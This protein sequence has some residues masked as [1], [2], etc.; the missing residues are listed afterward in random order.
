MPESRPTSPL[1][2]RF[3][4]LGL[5]GGAMVLLPLAQVLRYQT[6]E[7]HALQ[8]ERSALDPMTDALA[9]QR[10]LLQHR[11]LAH[12]VLTGRTQFERERRMRQRTVD[13]HVAT[14]GRA[15]I[16]GAWM[17]A[18]EESQA[19]TDDWNVLAGRVVARSISAPASDDEHRLRVEQVLQVIDLLSLALGRADAAGPGEP[20]SLAVATATLRAL[21]RLTAQMQA[22][23]E[24][25]RDLD[26][27]A[28]AAGARS[29]ERLQRSLQA[30]QATLASTGGQALAAAGLATAAQTSAWAAHRG[31]PDADGAALAA[32]LQAQAGLAAAAARQAEAALAQQQ[33]AVEGQRAALLAA[34]AALSCTALWLWRRRPLPAAGG[35]VPREP[36]AGGDG[37]T[38]TEAGRLLRRLRQ[39]GR[40]EARQAEPTA[41]ASLPPL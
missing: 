3:A 2:P 17:R 31:E 12:Q 35:P 39:P 14:L 32:A 15:L 6:A 37:P 26:R 20:G 25:A 16:A 4:A 7:V 23:D 28:S 40:P 24:P 33:A 29:E 19:L 9:L 30:L 22:L 5:V 11:R 34:L 27:P 18:H 41:P 21:P 8:A 1:R 13:T 36:A 38:D 10:S